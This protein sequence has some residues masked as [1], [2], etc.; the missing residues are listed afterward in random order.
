MTTRHHDHAL[1]DGRERRLHPEEE[2]VGS[3]QPE[4]EDSDDRA[5]QSAATAGQAHAPSTM[6]ATLRRR[7]GPGTGWPMPVLAVSASPPSAAKKPAKAYD[8]DLRPAHVDAAAEGSQLV[9]ADRVER[10][11]EPRPPQ[12]DPDREDDHQQE[13]QGAGQQVDAQPA[14]DQVTEPVD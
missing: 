11:T 5:E 8:S 12:R 14:V 3:D 9:G 4:D 10:E 2:Q 13:D 6:A 7:Y 1:D